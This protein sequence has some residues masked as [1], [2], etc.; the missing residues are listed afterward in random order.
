MLSRNTNWIKVENDKRIDKIKL[1]KGMENDAWLCV[2]AYR[3]VWVCVHAGFTCAYLWCSL[4]WYGQ[5]R[6]SLWFCLELN[7]NLENSSSLF[8]EWMSNP[9]RT[10]W[11]V[12]VEG[13]SLLIS[14]VEY[15]WSKG[16]F[17]ALEEEMEPILVG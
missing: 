10:Q 4:R 3:S 16:K 9:S 13:R 6:A 14:V 1:D 17:I 15:F 12:L 8:G 11:V 2:C 7:R 5:Q